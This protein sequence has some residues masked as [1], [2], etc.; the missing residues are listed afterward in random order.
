MIKILNKKAQMQINNSKLN[1]QKEIIKLSLFGKRPR[2]Q[3]QE[4][5]NN[6]I[7][8]IQG[9]DNQN[10]DEDDSL[11]FFS[12]NQEDQEMKNV[13]EEVAQ[14]QQQKSS[15]MEEDDVAAIGNQQIGSLQTEGLSGLQKLLCPGIKIYIKILGF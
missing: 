2:T 3:S 8:E 9:Q 4:S 14:N 7:Q 5:V 15:F 6:N 13:V 11:S 1:M 12:D 10:Q